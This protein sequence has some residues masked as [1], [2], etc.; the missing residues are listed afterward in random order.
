LAIP[1]SLAPFKQVFSASSNI[2]IKK[3]NCIIRENIKYLLSLRSWGII[4]EDNDFDNKE[5]K[6]DNSNNKER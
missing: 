2:I 5:Y 3:R 1:A 6:E 4:S